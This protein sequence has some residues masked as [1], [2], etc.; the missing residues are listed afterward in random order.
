MDVVP[1]SNSNGV[2]GSLVKDNIVVGENGTVSIKDLVVGTPYY[3]VETKAPPGYNSLKEPI[4][5]IIEEESSGQVLKILDGDRWA[6]VTSTSDGLSM[7]VSNEK[8]YMLPKTGGP[9]SEMFIIVGAILMVVTALL[10]LKK[11]V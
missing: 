3:L 2:Y 9:G 1:I 5:F 4:S 7:Q 6:K 11:G 10:Y 8:G